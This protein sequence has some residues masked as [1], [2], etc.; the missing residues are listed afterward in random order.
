ML[1]EAIF[2]EGLRVKYTKFSLRRFV[3]TEEVR[4]QNYVKRAVIQEHSLIG[5]EGVSVDFLSHELHRRRY[6]AIGFRRYAH[7]SS[8]RPKFLSGEGGSV[9]NCNDNAFKL[10]V[11]LYKLLDLVAPIVRLGNVVVLYLF[12]T[13]KS[14][15]LSGT[16]VK[17]ELRLL[18]RLAIGLLDRLDV[19]LVVR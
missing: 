8:L 15:Q 9:F 6:S 7:E 14:R 13:V 4:S 10:C 2:A 1:W 18:L 11:G 3:N 12:Q 19:V 17:T 16:C 5:V